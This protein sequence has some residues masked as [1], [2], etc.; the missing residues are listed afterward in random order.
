[1]ERKSSQSCRIVVVRVQKCIIAA[2][3][4]LLWGRPEMTLTLDEALVDYKM[5]FKRLGSFGVMVQPE[6]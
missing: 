2:V 3:D 6:H 5:H 1:M 4:T